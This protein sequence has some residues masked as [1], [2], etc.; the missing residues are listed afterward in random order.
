MPHGSS[1]SLL[2]LPHSD[3]HRPKGKCSKV[4]YRLFLSELL[5]QSPYEDVERTGEPSPPTTVRLWGPTMLPGH[6][7]TKL[8]LNPSGTLPVS[9]AV[10]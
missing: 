1:R 3:L 7:D 8:I 10:R 9:T 4:S 2:A 6:R 5:V